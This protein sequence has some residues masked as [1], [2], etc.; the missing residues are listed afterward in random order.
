[1]LQDNLKLKSFLQHPPL[2]SL[3]TVHFLHI[4]CHLSNMQEKKCAN[5]QK[6]PRVFLQCDA[7]R[8]RMEISAKNEDVLRLLL[9]GIACYLSGFF[10][11]GFSARSAHKVS[12]CLSFGRKTCNYVNKVNC[13]VSSMCFAYLWLLKLICVSF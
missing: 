5:A 8:H 2:L 13:K 7:A 10:R 6:M 12:N 3:S 4:I 11:P 9:L 1:M